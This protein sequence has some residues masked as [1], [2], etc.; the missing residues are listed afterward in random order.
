MKLPWPELLST[1]RPEETIREI[2]DYLCW[3]S[4]E[5][6]GEAYAARGDAACKG[7]R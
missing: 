4:T 3:I 5:M 7:R 2:L 1:Q 6:A